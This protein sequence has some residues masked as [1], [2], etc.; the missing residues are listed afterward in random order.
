MSTAPLLICTAGGVAGLMSA[1]WL[2]SLWRRDVSV[3][4]ILWGLGFACVALLAHSL[5][6]E[7]RRRAA[8]LTALTV[9]WGVRLALYLLWRNWGQPEDYRYQAMRRHHGERFALVSLVTVFGLQG[10]LM[11][12]I[13]LPVQL[14]QLNAPPNELGWLD[15]LGLALWLIG[16]GC[17]TIG[18]AQLARFKSD[19]QNKGKVMD[20]GLWRYTRHPNY[21]GDALLWWG[22]YLIAAS[23]P[24]GRW[25]LFSPILM[26]GLLL[27]VSGVPL[28]ERKLVKTRPAYAEYIRRTS[29]FVPD[30]GRFVRSFRV[31]VKND[32]DQTDHHQRS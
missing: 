5:A 12:L 8:L 31:S 32:D 6:G 28:L 29:S 19:P 9:V 24:A 18:D 7:G 26:T 16:F 30:L 22:L 3:V 20:R 27:R 17:E 1:V 21:F 15:G 13:S 4:D 14:G 2:F 10:V 11:W 25:A 23:T